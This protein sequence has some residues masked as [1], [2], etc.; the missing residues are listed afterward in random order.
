MFIR[1]LSSLAIAVFIPTMGAHA[2]DNYPDRP[3]KIV[4]PFSTGGGGDYIARSWSN[5]LSENLKQPVVI[6]NKGGGGTV[7]GTQAVASAPPDGY[8]VLFV[9]QAIAANPFLR[10]NMTYQTPGSFAPVAKLITYAMGFAARADAPFSN[11]QEL[12]QYGKQ[13]PEKLT[14]ATSGEGSAT[15]LAAGQFMQATGL[16]IVKVPFKGSGAAATAVASGHV[17]LVFTGMSQIKPLLDGKRVKLIATSGAKRMQS[18][19]NVPTV[20]EQGVAGFD[21]VVWWGMLAPA[22]TP[23]AVIDKLN[24]A[25]RASLAKPEVAKRLAVI[26]G[27][28]EVSSPAQFSAF[29]D[30]E[31]KKFSQLIKPAAKK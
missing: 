21:A 9:S 15:D 19:P 26:D 23:G 4:V 20:A 25:L 27:E 5:E 29:I 3:I 2:A 30:V 16:N 7:I 10:S 13:N 6:E 14:I 18:L 1:F 31:M 24:Q 28:I 12:I 11:V 8:T 17:D 22:G